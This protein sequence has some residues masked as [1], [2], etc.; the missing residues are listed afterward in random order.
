MASTEL[1]S[2]VPADTAGITVK[3][4]PTPSKP[5]SSQ[6]GAKKTQKNDKTAQPTPNSPTTPPSAPERP[7]APPTPTPGPT[8]QPAEQPKGKPSPTP[9]P[10]PPPSPP[11]EANTESTSGSA[12][13]YVFLGII[14]LMLVGFAGLWLVRKFRARR[15]PNASMID[16]EHSRTHPVALPMPR[17]PETSYFAVTASSPSVSSF[18]IPSSLQ[19]ESD[20]PGAKP[21]S[22][23]TYGRKYRRPQS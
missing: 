20:S 8:P 17:H 21:G 2:A 10:A 16:L 18:A 15:S 22:P 3:Q 5:T 12:L 11:V 14:A 19:T 1:R 7:T 4:P 23:G 9:A 13:P 6:P